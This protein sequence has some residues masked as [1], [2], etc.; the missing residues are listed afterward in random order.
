MDEPD[1]GPDGDLVPPLVS[2]AV[3]PIIVNAF[4]SG[5]YDVYSAKQTRRVL[6]LVDLLSVYI[7]KENLKFR[8]S[9]SHGNIETQSNTENGQNNTRQS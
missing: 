2:A 9:R 3:I 1:L 6:D 4:E 8:V 7:G 5:A